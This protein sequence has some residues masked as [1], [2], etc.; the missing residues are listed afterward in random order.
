MKKWLSIFI[1]GLITSL[2]FSGCF[3][4]DDETVNAGRDQQVETGSMVYLHATVGSDVDPN[5][6][7]SWIFI[8]PMGSSAVLYDAN[9][10][11]PYFIADVDGYYYLEIRITV[12]T[13]LYNNPIKIDSSVTVLATTGNFPPIA[14]AGDDQ[15]ALVGSIVNL[16]GSRSSDADDDD[17]TYT[18]SLTTPEGSSSVLSNETTDTPSFIPDLVGSYLVE[19]IVNDG[20]VDSAP[21]IMVVTATLD[22]IAPVADAGDDQN[23]TTYSTVDLDGSGSSDPDGDDLTYSW[24]LIPPVASTTVL[25]GATTITSSFIPD[26]E[27]TYTVE[28][29]VND[30][31]VD[32]APD[33]M[34]VTVT[35]DN[36]APVAD[37]GDDQNATTDSTVEL[38]GS[39]SSDP[40]GD[41]LTYSWTLIPP[42]G[43]NSVL[44]NETTVTPS[45]VPD[46][47][48]T[49]TVELMVNDGTV[50]SAPDT[51]IVTVT[52][53]NVAP[54]AN[55]G[56]DQIVGLGLSVVLDGTA[57]SDA[58]GDTLTFSW[59][60]SL[61]AGSTAFLINETT[62][63]PSFVPDG[64][65]DYTI[66][67]IVN[68]G[69]L[70]SAPDTVIIV[71]VP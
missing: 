37:A 1:L 69:T 14:D 2:L 56:D 48:G 53:V 41:D 62:A 13:D 5:D 26:L 51:M 30:G 33:I 8:P 63:T 18:W 39:G 12:G 64:E 19:L 71:G 21:D 7:I 55:A 20:T 6:P 54:V 58:N 70:D 47:E 32:S 65:G 36:I 49:Y 40:D 67:L 52:G 43:S 9:T 57:S 66:E 28:L 23:A 59:T 38:D 68:D 50:D 16:D 3:T 61:P 10:L 11:N 34:V 60:M 17:L 4:T 46:L 45:F 25:N 42:T 24:V 29:I 35:L 22:N 31:T 27:G 44:S 15:A